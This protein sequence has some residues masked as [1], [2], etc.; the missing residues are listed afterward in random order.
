[1]HGLVQPAFIWIQATGKPWIMAVSMIV[2]LILYIIYLP[3]MTHHYGI[4]GAAIAWNIRV[5]GA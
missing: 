5:A 1:M 2:D 3:W 4:L